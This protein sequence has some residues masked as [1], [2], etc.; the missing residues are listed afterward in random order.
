MNSEAL[1]ISML[2][3]EIITLKAEMKSRTYK[4]EKNDEK[5]KVIRTNILNHLN[6]SL[7]DPLFETGSMSLLVT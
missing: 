4:I 1:K 6:Q 3:R 5:M 7:S 2:K